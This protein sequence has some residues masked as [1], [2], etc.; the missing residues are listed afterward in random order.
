M[1]EKEKSEISVSKVYCTFGSLSWCLWEQKVRKQMNLPSWD[2]AL[3]PPP[4]GMGG[5]DGRW[6]FSRRR[7]GKS[8]DGQTQLD[9][10]SEHT[11]IVVFL[12]TV[13]KTAELV[14]GLRFF[15]ASTCMQLHQI[16]FPLIPGSFVSI[17]L[18]YC[19]EPFFLLKRTSVGNT[20]A[21]W[22]ICTLNYLSYW[23]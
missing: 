13:N 19:T 5:R 23:C 3:S 14:L 20:A 16:F 15:L 10:F 6:D 22:L 1:R 12:N 8:W 17:Y 9:F 18:Q 7:L 21:S 11:G 4:K 2:Q